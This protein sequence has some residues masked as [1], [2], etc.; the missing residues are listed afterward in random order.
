MVPHVRDTIADRELETW[1]VVDRSAS[2]DFGTAQ[3]EKRDLA[4]GDGGRGRLPH[5][6]LREPRR[7]RSSSAT[8]A[9]SS[10]RRGPVAKRCS[11]CC[12]RSTACP[13]PDVARPP[14]GDLRQPRCARVAASSHAAAAWWWSSPTSSTSSEWQPPL[15]ALAVRHDVLA[16][17]ILDPREI[18]LPPVGPGHAR[19]HR[20]RPPRGSADREREG[21]CPLRRGRGRANAP[22][23]RATSAAPVPSTWCCAPTATGSSI[24][25][26]T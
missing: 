18:E 13:A 3:F 8:T 21:P 9:P 1:I 16:V 24:S 25:P 12:T 23:S 11:R 5:Q 22:R 17:E 26:S 19:R 4:L 7:R 6:P 14:A 20:D 15:R 10:C 2:L